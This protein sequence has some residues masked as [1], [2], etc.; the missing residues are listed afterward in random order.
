[1][2]VTVIDTNILIDLFHGDSVTGLE[3]A[4]YDRI[5]VPTV[6]VGEFKSGIN[7]GTENGKRQGKCLNEFLDS[8]AVEVVPVSEETADCYSRIFRFLKSNGIPK[9]QNDIWIAASAVEHNAELLSH[10]SHFGD[11]PL[12]KIAQ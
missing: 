10:D 4:R 5:L 7:S 11:I 2:K 9:A 12:L 1:M 8:S 3:I 6:V